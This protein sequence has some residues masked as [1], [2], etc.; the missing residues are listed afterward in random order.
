MFLRNFVAVFVITGSVNAV[1]Y[2]DLTSPRGLQLGDMV[3]RLED[4]K[5]ANRTLEDRIALQVNYGD[6]GVS[7][8]ENKENDGIELDFFFMN[9]DNEGEDEML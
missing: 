6:V 8:V 5:A 3:F 2:R 4:T 9:K 1:W 7:A